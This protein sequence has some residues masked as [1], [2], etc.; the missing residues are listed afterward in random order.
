MKRTRVSHPQ[1]V[2]QILG[3]LEK[4]EVAE[5]GKSLHLR[6]LWMPRGRRLKLGQ[7][8]TLGSLIPATKKLLNQWT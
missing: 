5:P 4:S 2:H 1:S 6:D 7:K 3:S 8:K